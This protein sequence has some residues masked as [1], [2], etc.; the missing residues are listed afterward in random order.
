MAEKITLRDI[1]DLFK[2]I[3]EKTK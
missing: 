1:T 2:K 3:I